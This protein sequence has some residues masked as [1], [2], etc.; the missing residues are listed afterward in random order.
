MQKPTDHKN[1]EIFFF[2]HPMQTPTYIYSQMEMKNLI[3]QSAH[4]PNNV[5]NPCEFWLNRTN[6]LCSC[7][8]KQTFSPLANNVLKE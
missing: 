1:T 5:R 8:G 4:T 7:M 3:T 2:S 6:K